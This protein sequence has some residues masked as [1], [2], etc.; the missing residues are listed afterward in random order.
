M[1][2]FEHWQSERDDAGVLWLGADKADGSANVLSG[3]VLRELDQ[4]ITDAQRNPPAALVIHSKKPS[5]FVM[6]ADINEFTRLA[7]EH[8]AYE[9]VRLGQ[10]VLDRLE[11]ATFPTVAAIDGFALGG[12]LELAMACHYRVAV[13]SD[14]GTIG[15]PEV[16]LGIHPG[17]G[18]TVRAI[19]LAGVADAM[20]LMLTGKSIKPAK[21]MQ[22][23]LVDAVCSRDQLHE[24]AAEIAANRPARARAP[25]S[26]RLLNLPGVRGI[27]ANG[28]RKQTAAKANPAHYPAPFAIID[29]WRQHGASPTTGY[30]AEARSIARLMVGNT[31]QNLVRVFFLQNKL[32]GQGNKPTTQVAH[33][34]VVGAGV[35]GGDIAAWCALRGLRVSLQDR[36]MKYIEPALARAH[37]LFERKIRD[38]TKLE[39]TRNNLIADVE[40]NEVA[41][42]DLVIEA[43]FE[44]QEAKQSLYQQLVAKMKPGAILASNTSSIPLEILRE[45]L[46]EPDRFIGLHFF[47]PVAQLPLV[48]VIEADGAAAEALDIGLA[49]VKRIA[50]SPL[51]CKSAP[52]FVVNRILA[53]YMGEAFRLVS[54]GYAKQAID[55]A[56]LAFGMPMG[57]VELA[58]T[59]GLDVGL[60]VSRVLGNDESDLGELIEMVDAGHVGRK[61]G[62]GF[63]EWVEGKAVK[64][65]Q[66]DA[67]AL[68]ENVTDRLILPMVREAILCLHEG[69][70][71][72]ED[73]LDAGIIFGTGFAP[74][75]GG[76]LRYAR[77]RG[78]EDVAAALTEL[79][80]QF[81]DRFALPEAAWTSLC[82]QQLRTRSHVGG[83]ETGPGGFW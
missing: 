20:P 44:N 5:G 49:F 54:E 43:I 22:L 21:A 19:Q 42:A 52:G 66:P 4:L 3:P 12:G 76:P 35:M 68:P 62:K 63:Y 53:P 28:I 74:F 34:H 79:N 58:D 31:A 24:K 80:S 41:N 57:P 65:A 40:A 33:V 36:E 7:N 81:G 38:A 18:G 30:D 29:L 50:K 51:L 78:I 71:A 10:Q 47:N 83:N 37:K 2:E 72:S 46:P 77:E 16:K 26:K 13:D 9:L 67:P 45:G 32:K 1:S 64:P 6:G 39:A 82:H 14:K 27:V 69:I 59:V 61:A 60:S 55:K 70:V 11:Q 75:R 73:L 25:L 56:A 8:E 15:L 23:G 48:E 17:F